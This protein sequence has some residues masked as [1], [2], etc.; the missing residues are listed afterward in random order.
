MD[1]HGPQQ[2]CH[3]RIDFPG[4]IHHFDLEPGLHQHLIQEIL[5]VLRLP[6]GC[7]GLE[8]IGFYAIL[9]HHLA[10]SL[11]DLHDFQHGPEGNLPGLEGLFPQT[12]LAAQFCND[13]DIIQSRIF[14]QLHGD[15]L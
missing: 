1:L 12:D 6:D 11:E 7:S 14:Y 3:L 13:P 8:D 2:G 15:I 9:P 5:L 10:V 4:H